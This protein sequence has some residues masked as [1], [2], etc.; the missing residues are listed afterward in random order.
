MPFSFLRVSSTC[1][2]VPLST[3]DASFVFSYNFLRMGTTNVCS[4]MVALRKVQIPARRD[5]GQLLQALANL[6]HEHGRGLPTL[7]ST[8]TCART[9][10]C[11]DD[12]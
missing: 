8:L 11:F 5:C 3:R 1:E 12:T 6:A 10:T 4:E 2:L 7:S 9:A